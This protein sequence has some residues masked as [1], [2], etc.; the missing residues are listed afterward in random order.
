MLVRRN[1]NHRIGGGVNAPPAGADVLVSKTLNDVRSTTYDVANH[2]ASCVACEIVDHLLRETIW[3]SRKRPL[4]MNPGDLPVTGR[5]VFTSRRGTHAS[6]RTRGISAPRYARQWFDVAEAQAL[7]LGERQTAARARQIAESVATGVAVASGV[8][9]FTNADAIQNYHARAPQFPAP[10]YARS[11]RER[12][13]VSSSYGDIP[14]SSATRST[15]KVVPPA[16][17]IK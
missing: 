15:V 8:G 12:K 10:L 17:P 3:K 2:A 6:P 4:E 16:L 11:T 1:L 13:P 7:E 5:T 14:A 9:G